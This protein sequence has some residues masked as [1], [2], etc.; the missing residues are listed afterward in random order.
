MQSRKH[1]NSKTTT[2]K[3][4]CVPDRVLSDLHESSHLFARTIGD[5]ITV[6]IPAVE[7]SF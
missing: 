5:D 3:I 6:I 4:Y 2:T 7:M 1:N